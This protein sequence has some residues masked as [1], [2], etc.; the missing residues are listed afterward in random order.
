M[1]L[2]P[3]S[4]KFSKQWLYLLAVFGFSLLAYSTV[5][6]IGIPSPI[7]QILSLPDS[8]L[9]FLA[10][11]VPLYLAYC[12]PGWL[13]TLSSFSA[14]L[15][16]FALQLSRYWRIAQA[17]WSIGGLLP[18]SDASYY[19]QGARNLLEGGNLSII[20][21]WR[22]L[23]SGTLGTILGLTQQNLQLTLAILVLINAICCFCLAREVQRSHGTAAG[24]ITLTLI[25]LFYRGYIGTTMTENLGLALGVVALT[26]L[27]RGAINQQIKPCLL[28]IF[29]L[30]VALNIRAGAY[31]ILPALI[32]WE[33][34]KF[35]GLSLFSW[36]FLLGGISLVLLGFIFNSIVFKVIG[37]PDT[38]ANSNFSYVFY[39]LVVN[40]NWLS[41]FRD[42]PE[43]G[44][45][46]EIEKS[47]KIYELA[48]EALRANP[49]NL[50]MA[51]LRAWKEFIFDGFIFSFFTG[52]KVSFTLQLLSLIGLVNLYRQR[53]SPITPLMLAVTIGILL[54]VPFVPPWDAGIRPYAVTVP[55]F[56]LFPAFGLALITQKIKWDHLVKFPEQNPQ[57]KLLMIFGCSLALL[58]V[59]GPIVTKILSHQPQLRD[60]SCPVD[61]E[62]VYFRKSAGSSL[63]LVPDSAI[64]SSYVPN[65]RIS[66]FR[67]EQKQV[68]QRRDRVP[69]EVAKELLNLKSNTTLTSK[70]NLKDGS[71]LWVIADSDLIPKESGIVAACGQTTTNSYAQGGNGVSLFYANSMK[72]INK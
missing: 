7:N 29:I 59:G 23:F 33:S 42:Y 38:V 9:L 25:F 69:S 66:D 19:Y 72:L 34:W 62:V 12:F 68:A 11:F 31:F 14:T 56:S 47:K 61:T 35:R 6:I 51:V 71:L 39:G 13:G 50:V 32:L 22:P 45:L 27:W 4:L 63:N 28:A 15:V 60:F 43:L 70:V 8:T 57:P 58:C 40:G 36:R 46:P 16:L 5:L 3:L 41:V 20:G 48:F 65:I 49:L 64:K 54:S 1:K 10:I 18:A 24:V 52:I 55:I 2:N 17:P 44:N 26:I 30:T 21:S 67:N 37:N 53:L